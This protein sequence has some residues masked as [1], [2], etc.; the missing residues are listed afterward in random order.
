MLRPHI[1]KQDP[2][3]TSTNPITYESSTHIPG[4]TIFRLF[5]LVGWIKPRREKPT[6]HVKIDAISNHTLYLDGTAYDFEFLETTFRNSTA[7]YSAQHDN[8]IVGFVRVLSDSRQR[9]VLYDFVVNPEY[10]HL[11]IGTML[12]E[13]CLKDFSQTQITLGTSS[14][15]MNF[16]EKFGFARSQNYMELSTEAF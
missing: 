8:E 1:P 16:Y 11:G 13:R 10:Q 5:S 14:P 6:V 12:L 7:I 3:L 9:S 4:E 2:S 15:N